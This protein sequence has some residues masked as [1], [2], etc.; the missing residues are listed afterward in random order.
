M[1]PP[2][3]L[4]PG[5]LQ[6]SSVYV[7]TALLQVLEALY[8]FYTG[9]GT[10]TLNITPVEHPPK[11]HYQ[12]TTNEYYSRLATAHYQLVRCS[13]QVLLIVCIGRMHCG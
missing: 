11:S 2:V 12:T 9:C 1:F 3:Y 13:W 7:C 4:K 8:G 10:N 6:P 5:S